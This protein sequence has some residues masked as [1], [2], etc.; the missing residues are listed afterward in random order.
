MP[1]AQ[2]W[3]PWH[4]SGSAEIVDNRGVHRARVVGRLRLGTRPLLAYRTEVRGQRCLRP[5]L[6]ES[7]ADKRNY[8]W[9]PASLIADSVPPEQTVMA[10]STPPFSGCREHTWTA[11]ADARGI[12]NLY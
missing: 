10:G 1:D 4:T 2:V 6:S 9:L 8:P 7:S 5:G 11:V 12:K 3:L